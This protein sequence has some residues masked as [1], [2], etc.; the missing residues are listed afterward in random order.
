MKKKNNTLIVLII[1]VVISLLLYFNSNKKTSSL[2]TLESSYC[3]DGNTCHM[4]NSDMENIYKS[5]GW[6]DWPIF[7]TDLNSFEIIWEANVEN[8]AYIY[9][10]VNSVDNLRQLSD[11][12]TIILISELNLSAVCSVDATS[13]AQWYITDG[14]TSIM[15]S[16]IC[17]RDSSGNGPQDP[18]ISY[19]NIKIILKKNG[20]VSMYKNCESKDCIN[21]ILI[22]SA[23]FSPQHLWHW[24]LY[25]TS[26][27]N[28]DGRPFDSPGIV[29]I[30]YNNNTFA[31]STL[32]CDLCSNV[33][34]NN[35][36]ENDIFYQDGICN[37]G[38]CT[39]SQS[40]CSDDCNTQHDACN[41]VSPTS[42]PSPSPTP[43][44]N[45]SYTPTPTPT[46]MPNATLTPA[47][48]STPEEPITPKDN[49]IYYVAGG[50][51]IIGLIGLAIKYKWLSG[52]I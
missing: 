49:T 15:D 6:D 40:V 25:A 37:L 47:P 26:N 44:T 33:T 9:R 38:I 23:N 24:K 20:E 45:P 22:K 4:C 28:G 35:K 16:V 32:N 27:K 19:S 29:R 12:D 34:C 18:P 52:F 30:Y 39:Y 36:C 10:T 2:F 42:T 43:T 11:N 1:I 21:G 50:I 51:G 31:S 14:T 48:T 17:S 3:Y 5:N 7:N 13:S 8:Q 46:T 41:V